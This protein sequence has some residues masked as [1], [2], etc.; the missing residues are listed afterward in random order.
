MKTK[1]F[2]EAIRTETLGF[3]LGDPWRYD[4]ASITCVLPIVRQTDE[5]EVYVTLVQAQKENLVEIKDTGAIGNVLILNKG[6]LPVFL[7]MGELL[8]GATQNRTVTMSRLIF[9]Q[10]KEIV[11]VAC[12]H[13]S[14]GIVSGTSLSHGCYTPERDGQYATSYHARGNIGQGMSWNADREYHAAAKSSLVSFSC[15]DGGMSEKAKAGYAKVTSTR[16]DDLTKVRDQ[17]NEV[18]EEVLK[19]V[20]LVDNQIGMALIDTKGFHSLDCFSLHAPWRSVKE[21]LVGKES[22]T[23]SKR[24][25]GGVFVYKPKKAKSTVKDVLKRGCE[26]KSQHKDDRAETLTLDFSEYIGEVVL[27]DGDVVHLLIARKEKI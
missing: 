27:L 20:P 16:S 14:R 9:P 26:E 4:K 15:G 11:D 8:K 2:L 12:V 10:Q 21:A 23:I 24:D 25:E 22:L 17:Y 18:M 5:P 3:S 7:R 6:E 1:V 13:A 19:D